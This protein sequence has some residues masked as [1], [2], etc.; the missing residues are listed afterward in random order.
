MAASA[1][2]CFE[3]GM[4]TWS[5][6]ARL[7]LRTRVS[8]AAMGSV[9]MLMAPLRARRPAL[10]GRS[11]LALLSRRWLGVGDPCAAR[12]PPDQLAFV[13]PGISPAWASSRRQMRHSMNLR[14]TDLGRPHRRQRVYA[15][16]L[17]FGLRC[18]FSIRAFFAMPIADLLYEM[19]IRKRRAKP[20][21]RRRYLRW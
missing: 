12:S 21:L 2:F 16:T 10:R 15:R 5:C 11:S 8:M 17:N 4:R 1:S 3:E 18:C 13:T 20:C 7:A 19:G 14:Y 6:M 9:I